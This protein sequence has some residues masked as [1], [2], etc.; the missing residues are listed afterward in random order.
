MKVKAVIG[1]VAI[2]FVHLGADQCNLL[3]SL[4]HD[5]L[6]LLVEVVRE[7]PTGG[8]MNSVWK[9][10]LPKLHVKVILDTRTSHVDACCAELEP[11]NALRDK[12][13]EVSSHMRSQMIHSGGNMSKA[14]WSFLSFSN[15]VCMPH[16]AT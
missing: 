6:D 4:L 11:A 16:A 2:C 13:S 14:A 3:Q 5:L 1:R 10:V 12:R 8:M 9:M 7:Q 15:C